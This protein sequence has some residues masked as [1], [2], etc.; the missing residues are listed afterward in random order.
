MLH[1]KYLLIISGVFKEHRNAIINTL[2][3]EYR[4]MRATGES[5]VSCLIALASKFPY[6]LLSKKVML[7]NLSLVLFH[8]LFCFRFLSLTLVNSL[9]N[10]SIH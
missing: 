2:N 10:T 5:Q 1:E 6:R 7:I 3:E 9:Y 8:F 4:D